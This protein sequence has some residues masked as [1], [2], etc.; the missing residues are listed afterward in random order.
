MLKAMK[1]IQA[2][3]Y[4]RMGIQA[5]QFARERFDSIML[6]EKIFGKKKD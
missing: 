2:T 5:A 1:K 4:K 3:D 6:C